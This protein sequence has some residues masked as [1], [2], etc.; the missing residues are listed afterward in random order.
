[1]IPKELEAKIVR[2]HLA[3]RWRIGTIARELTLHHTTVRRVLARLGVPTQ[4]HAAPRASLLDPYRGFVH[5]VLE[6]YPATKGGS[7]RG[8]GGGAWALPRW[9]APKYRFS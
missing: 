4:P 7:C 1:V 5:E 9:G 8:P 2:L 3:E 6:K